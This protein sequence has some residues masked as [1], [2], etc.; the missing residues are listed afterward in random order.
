MGKGLF[1]SGEKQYHTMNRIDEFLEKYAI[2]CVFLIACLIAVIQVFFS[3]SLWLDEAM[4]SL[5][6]VDKNFLELLRPLDRNQVAPIGYLFLVKFLFNVLGNSEFSL[7]LYSL[8]C[9]FG[10]FY[11]IFDFFKDYFSKKT[12][13]ALL[14]V[15]IFFNFF[16]L[17]YSFEVKQYIG[18]VFFTFLLLKTFDSNSTVAKKVVISF[19]AI[20]FSNV[21]VL[22]LFCL[23]VYD[24]LKLIKSRN[25]FKLLLPYLLVIPFFAVYYWF[26]IHNHPTKAFM[27]DFWNENFFPTN[28]SSSEPL[29]FVIK[30]YNWA[31]ERFITF[32]FHP[33]ILLLHDIFV[34]VMIMLGLVFNVIKKRFGILFLLIAPI[35]LHLILSSLKLYPV[36]ARL[37]LYLFPSLIFLFVSGIVL[38]KDVLINKFIIFVSETL[39]FSLVVFV[40]YVVIKSLPIQK[41][42]IKKGID[43]IVKNK[44]I[45]QD[46]LIHYGAASA[47]EYYEKTKYHQLKPNGF[48]NFFSFK[49]EKEDFLRKIKKNTWILLTYYPWD[50]NED[51]F[52]LIKRIATEQSAKLEIAEFVGCKVIHVSY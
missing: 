2:L 17:Y 21:A 34:G 40:F 4:L 11:L 16:F 39:K 25:E 22:N 28:F 47:F 44:S 20:L 38:I 50:G 33:K 19:I 30:E 23:G 32:S 29:K 49:S 9:Y 3:R 24:F 51:D 42:E 14:L 15:L 5:N 43:F 46:L 37:I 7:R 31:R 1:G 8:F 6:F 48:I 12:D 41:E 52:K 27:L 36:N 35:F 26:F 18:D 10:A 13:L 45:D